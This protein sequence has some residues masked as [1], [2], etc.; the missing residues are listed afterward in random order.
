MGIVSLKVGVVKQKFLPLFAFMYRTRTPLFKI[1]D[2]SLLLTTVCD[3]VTG[4]EH[5][6]LAQGQHIVSSGRYTI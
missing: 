2:P 6:I 4:K 3:R 1:L 5:L